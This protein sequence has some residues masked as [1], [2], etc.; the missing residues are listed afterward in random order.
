MTPIPGRF[1][2]SNQAEFKEAAPHVITALNSLPQAIK[3]VITSSRRSWGNTKN[4]SGMHPVGKA[5]DIRDD[6]DSLNF[7]NWLDTPEG[8]QWKSS[9]KVS[10]LKEGN[11]YHVEFNK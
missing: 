8:L 6:N 3:F 4:K 1:N 7:W 11:H 9:N 5:I 2:V 10:I